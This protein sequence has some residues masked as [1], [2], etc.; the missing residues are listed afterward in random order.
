MRT[1]IIKSQEVFP[2]LWNM[3]LIMWTTTSRTVGR[4]F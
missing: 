1:I 3:K 2:W 4:W